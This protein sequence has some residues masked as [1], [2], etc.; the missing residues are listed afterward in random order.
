MQRPRIFIKLFL[1]AAM[2]VCLAPILPDKSFE[3]DAQQSDTQKL[4]DSAELSLVRGDYQNALDETE[5]LLTSVPDYA[6]ALLLK[7]RALLGLFANEP[8]LPV[9]ERDSADARSSRKL[10]Q[11]TRLTNAAESL[12]RFLQ[13]KPDAEGAAGLREQLDSLRFHAEKALAFEAE[14]TVF[15][16]SEVTERARILTRPEPDIPGSA[17][18]ARISGTVK[19]LAVFDL[20]GTVKHILVIQPLS[21]G[22]TEASIEAARKIKFTPAVKDGRR[23]SMGIQIEYN[24]R[25]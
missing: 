8:P 2:F 18:R 9:S 24:F 12:E 1:I 13:L 17:S 20:D 19:L 11:S 22:L 21:H 10:R 6:P 23:V 25:S 4:S 14:R 15:S 16:G 7:Y 3:V 5:A